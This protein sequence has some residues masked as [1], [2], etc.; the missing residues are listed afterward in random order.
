VGVFERLSPRDAGIAVAHNQIALSYY[1]ERDYERCVEA[2]R[3][4]LSASLIGEVEVKLPFF[5]PSGGSIVGSITP[6]TAWRL[7]VSE[8]RQVEIDDGFERRGCRAAL[9]AIGEC[10]EPV[11][12]L[13]LQREQCA[14]GVTPTLRAA[15]SIGRSALGDGHGRFPLLARAIAGLAFGVAQRVLTCR[16]AAPRHKLC[17]PL[18]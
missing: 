12:V 17:S 10:C 14:D 9:E 7:N 6:V 16:F 13:S 5:H 3:R 8:G 4:Q 15:A 2:A 1:F 11:G 18:L